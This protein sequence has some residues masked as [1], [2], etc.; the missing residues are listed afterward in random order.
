MDIFPNGINED[1]DG[2]DEEKFNGMRYSSQQKQKK[3]TEYHWDNNY[4]HHIKSKVKYR[5]QAKGWI[6]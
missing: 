6:P 5:I 3:Y 1:Q 4:Q 2:Y